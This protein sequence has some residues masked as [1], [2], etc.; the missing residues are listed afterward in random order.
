MNKITRTLIVFTIGLS[1]GGGATHLAHK[2]PTIDAE[3]ELSQSQNSSEP[4]YWVAPMDPNFRK[5]SP[6]K[7]PMGMNLIPVYNSASTKESS[8]TIKISPEVINNLGVRTTLIKQNTLI[9]DI[10]TVGY[11]NYDGN[12]LSHIHSRT[13]GWVETLY[14]KSSGEQVHAGQALY[15]LYS[16][17]LVNA[18]E[19][20]LLALSRGNKRLIQAADDRLKALQIPPYILKQLKQ[21]QKVSQTII[22][23]APH[24]GVVDRLHIREGFFVKPSQTIMSIGSLDEV[25]VE[26]EVFER[27]AP[28]VQP[29]APVTMTLNYLPGQTWRG[30]VD[31]VYPVVNATNRTV[32]VRMRFINDSGALKPNMFAEVL[33]HGNK[34]SQTLVAPKEAL[35]R[36]GAMNRLVLALGQGRFRSVVVKTGRFDSDNIEILSGAKEGDRVVTSAQFLLDSESSK[37]SDFQRMEEPSHTQESSLQESP[38]QES[39][40]V[41]GII[42][43]IALEERIIN[44]SHGAIQKWKH[45]VMSMDFKVDDA[46]N[47]SALKVGMKV[48]ISFIIRDGIFLVTHITPQNKHTTSNVQTNGDQR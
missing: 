44:I 1:L 17:T 2:L 31:Y 42:N 7:S 19:E 16:P 41:E 20:F 14:V 6:G 30:A 40:D 33:I 37:F 29:G 5:D 38:Q 32:K 10:K 22:F 23:F 34:N 8:G 36:T 3:P 15:S 47:L 27:Q 21:H 4:L 43:S 45:P 48:H 12:K 25:W 24:S 18:Q 46:L 35:I 13:E 11:V 9:N 28:L 26:A 39:A